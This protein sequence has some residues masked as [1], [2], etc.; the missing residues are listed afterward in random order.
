LDKFRDSR[1]K[2]NTPDDIVYKIVEINTLKDKVVLEWV[3]YNGEITKSS[4]SI[5]DA[6]ES[7]NNGNW[8][9]IED[10]VVAKPTPPQTIVP[11]PP[12]QKPTPSPKKAPINYEQAMNNWVANTLINTQTVSGDMLK[13]T[14]VNNFSIAINNVTQ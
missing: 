10:D 14:I 4:Y 12:R 1:A 7:F 9:K 3:H 2:K 8:V 5:K 11:I 13:E 6:T